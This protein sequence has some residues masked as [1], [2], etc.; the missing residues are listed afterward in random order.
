MKVFTLVGDSKRQQSGFV[1]EHGLSLYFEQGGKRILFDTGASDSFIYNATLLGIDLSSVDICIISH[2]HNDHTGGLKY[3]LS[4]NDS[5]KV[6]MKSDAA[7]E[8][9]IKRS[10]KLYKAGIDP[11][12]FKT[13]KDRI[14]FIKQDA[15]IAD[16]VYAVT[17][18]KHRHY[19]HFTSL[20][21]EKQDGELKKDDLEDELFVAVKHEDGAAVL[22]GCSHHGVLN[23]LMTAQEKFGSVK[24]VIGGFHLD[25]RKRFGVMRKKESGVELSAIAKYINDNKIKNVY[26]GHCIGDKAQEKLE[27]FA[28]AHKLYS[29]DVIEI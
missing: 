24:G 10:F 14:E 19:P 25:G 5:A 17:I 16:G 3:F 13:Y 11:E 4:L 26:I 6:Y 8:F 28:R 1:A 12:I 2:A 21:Y 9:Y 20:M 23:V 7:G 22:T 27:L 18:D 29:G 15:E